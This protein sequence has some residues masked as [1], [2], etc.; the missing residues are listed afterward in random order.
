MRLLLY[1]FPSLHIPHLHSTTAFPSSTPLL[2]FSNSLPLPVS[3]HHPLPNFPPS[4]PFPIS[5]LYPPSPILSFILHS[6]LLHLLLHFS[7]SPTPL[8]SSP[9]RP[10]PF[11]SFTP[12]PHFVPSSPPAFLSFIPLSYSSPSLPFPISFLHPSCTSPLHPPASL[13]LSFTPLSHFSPLLPS[14]IFFLSLP[15]S[16]HSP[17][18]LPPL[19]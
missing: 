13:F 12:L 5:P 17:P 16:I 1:C 3:L 4:L 2:Q 19:R 9:S 14:Y 8:C 11:L 18:I 6:L 7:P 10:S 15:S